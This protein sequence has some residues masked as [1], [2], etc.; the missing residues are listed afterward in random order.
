MGGQA[1]RFQG[2]FK[3]L[4]FSLA[5]LTQD[6]SICSTWDTQRLIQ[7]PALQMRPLSWWP[8]VQYSDSHEVIPW[9]V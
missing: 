6:G 3:Y 4:V 1:L 5:G 7:G 8:T 2:S 9:I